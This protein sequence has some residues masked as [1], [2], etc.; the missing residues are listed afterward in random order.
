[1]KTRNT[2][3]F[4]VLHNAGIISKLHQRNIKFSVKQDIPILKELLACEVHGMKSIPALMF[5]CPNY[6]LEELNLQRNT[7]Q[8]KKRNQ[9][10]IVNLINVLFKNKQM[11]NPTDHTE[12][13]LIA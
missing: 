11:Q 3:Y 7:L 13:L 2:H 1:M 8:T 9:K 10:S 5:S 4:T 12:S 6:T